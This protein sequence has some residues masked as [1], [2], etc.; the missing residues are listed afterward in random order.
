MSTPLLKEHI[1]KNPVGSLHLYL[2]SL[3]SPLALQPWI[4]ETSKMFTQP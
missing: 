3:D 4:L 2:I 1:G